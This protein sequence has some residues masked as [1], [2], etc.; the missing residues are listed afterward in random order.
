MNFERLSAVDPTSHE[1]VCQEADR[2]VSGERDRE[3]GHPRANMDTFAELAT[4]FLRGRGLLHAGDSLTGTDGA[5][6]C[7]LLKVARLATGNTKRDTV[8]DQAGYAEVT[9]RVLGLDP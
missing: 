4:A 6:L 9:A 1:T 5:Q 3:Y 7:L 2:L 8:V